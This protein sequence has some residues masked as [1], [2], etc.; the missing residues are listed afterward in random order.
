MFFLKTRIRES[1]DT[2]S[3]RY[4]CEYKTFLFWKNCNSYPYSPYG[5]RSYSSGYSTYEDAQRRI[6]KFLEIY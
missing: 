2:G 4:V 5:I 1:M 3:K 6:K